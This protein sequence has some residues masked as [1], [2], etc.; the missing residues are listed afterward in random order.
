MPKY[1]IAW[2]AWPYYLP[3]GN[4]VGYAVR[5][6]YVDQDGRPAKYRS[7]RE[8]YCLLPDGQQKWVAREI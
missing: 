3:D 7:A 5:I 1:G 8:T 6:D 4:L 2:G